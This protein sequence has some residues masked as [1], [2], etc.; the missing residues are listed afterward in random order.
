MLSSRALTAL[1]LV[2]GLLTAGVVAGTTVVDLDGDGR[3]VVAEVRDGTAPLEADTDGD[4]LDDDVESRLGT[5]PTAVDTDGDG[6]EDGT[7]VNEYGTDP[8]ATDTD[9][10]GLDDDAELDEYGTDPTAA[11][12]DGDGLDDS[13]EVGEYETDP[14]VADT[15]DDGLTDGLEVEAGTDPHDSDTDDDRLNDAAE[16]REYGTDPTDPDTDGDG[17]EDGM[18]RHLH[19]TD[20]TA[21]DTDGDGLDDGAE[22]DEYDTDPTD[23]DTDGDGLEDGTEIHREDRLP[24]ADPLRTDVYVEIDTMAGTDL[25]TAERDRIVDRFADAPLDN[26]DGSTGVDLHLVFDET[27]PREDVT[28]VDDLTRY[29]SQYFDGSGAGYHYLVIVNDVAG[30]TATTN[31]IGKATLGTMM[32]EAQPERHETGSTAMHE[33]GHSLGLSNGNFEGIDSDQYAFAQYPSVMNYNAPSDYYGFSTGGGD[34]DFDD[35][36]YL[37][38]SLF[39]PDTTSVAVE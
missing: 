12:T 6:L 38:E 33:L 15:D 9:G 35:W 34:R 8:T 31:V 20:P 13:V 2:I 17:L 36:G 23:P 24:D 3:S 11:D 16:R 1:V 7:E 25:S 5:D 10:D 14:T 29:R 18:E 39:T 19:G 30:G 26:P 28:D 22:V 32:V 4:G 37:G 21:A 27:L